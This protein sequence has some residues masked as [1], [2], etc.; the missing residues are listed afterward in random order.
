MKRKR[1]KVDEKLHK[2]NPLSRKGD[3]FLREKPAIGQGGALIGGAHFSI[4]EYHAKFKFIAKSLHY[5]WNLVEEASFI[6][7][8]KYS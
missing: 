4:I 5:I 2:R 1:I 3:D 6:N 7:C 8:G